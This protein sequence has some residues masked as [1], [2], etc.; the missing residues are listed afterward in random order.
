MRHEASQEGKKYA[1]FT[2]K[3][4]AAIGEYASLHGNQAAICH[5]S[6]K[7]GVEMKVTSVQTWKVSGHRG[8]DNVLVH[9][10]IKIR[11]FLLKALWPF[12]QKFAPP[13]ISCYTLHYT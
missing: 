7:L 9:M 2:P 1:K 12:I 10:K 3:Q 13:K 8:C 5:F 11:K 6:K 4:Q